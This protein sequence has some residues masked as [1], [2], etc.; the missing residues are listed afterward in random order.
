MAKA[1]EHFDVKVDWTAV[2][3]D[4]YPSACQVIRR[5]MPYG[6]RAIYD[7]EDFV[8]DAIVELMAHPERIGTKGSSTLILVAKRR[9]IDAA[10]SPR[11]RFMRL[12]VD[13]IDPQP[14]LVL[15]QEAAELRETMLR[16]TTDPDRRKLVDLRSRGH[17]LPEIAELSGVRLRTVQRFFKEFTAANEPY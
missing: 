10:R 17:T 6:L 5:L 16:R 13:V 12:E 15:E 1:G 7:P 8:A 11:S 3:R 14:P 2:M 9:M 4:S